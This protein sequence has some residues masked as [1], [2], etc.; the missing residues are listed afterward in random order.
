MWPQTR[1]PVDETL[2]AVVQWAEDGRAKAAFSPRPAEEQLQLLAE[3]GLLE[4]GDLAS[5]P[6]RMFSTLLASEGVT[7]SSPQ[8]DSVD[9]ELAPFVAALLDDDVH[10]EGLVQLLTGRSIFVSARVLR[11]SPSR[12]RTDLSD[13]DLLRL[14]Q[15]Y[16]AWSQSGQELSVVRGESWTAWRR[17]TKRE[18]RTAVTDAEFHAWRAEVA[19]DINLWP[20]LPLGERSPEFIA[21]IALLGDFRRTLLALD[22]GGDPHV[23]ASSEHVRSLLSRPL[24]FDR[25][26]LEAVE[27]RRSLHRSMFVAADLLGE[28]GIE[29][30]DSGGPIVTVRVSNAGEGWVEVAMG[31]EN[32]SVVRGPDP[33][34]LRPYR[35]IEL[36]VLLSGNQMAN[37]YAQLV[38]EV[39]TALGARL[40]AQSWS[41]A[42]LVPSWT[43]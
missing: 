35:A 24:D 17:S 2:A 6:H 23:S 41:K 5:F 8:A 7:E 20:H 36:G 38:R 22:P 31:G 39:E 10:A 25:T 29:Q 3:A 40:G 19:G 33:E 43:W 11:L 32:P 30:E 34:G 1:A 26:V 18:V 27:E 14:A 21:L 13:S 42:E 28:V 16:S 12:Q 15:A 37:V 4:I 9:D